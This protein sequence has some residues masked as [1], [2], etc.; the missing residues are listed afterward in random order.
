MEH[1]CIIVEGTSFNICKDCVDKLGQ[2]EKENWF[3]RN[4]RLAKEARA[5]GTSPWDILS[6]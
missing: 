3:V 6:N 5:N 1:T 4:I 2:E